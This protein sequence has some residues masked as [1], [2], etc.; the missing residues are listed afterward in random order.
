MAESIA[1]GNDS[2][3]SRVKRQERIERIANY[4]GFHVHR[5]SGSEGLMNSAPIMQ[6]A[7]RLLHPLVRAFKGESDYQGKVWVRHQFASILGQHFR[8]RSSNLVYEVF[9][10][11]R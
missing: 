2:E 10:I 4:W 5:N 11:R 8:G 7:L 3:T 9:S 6:A 1:K